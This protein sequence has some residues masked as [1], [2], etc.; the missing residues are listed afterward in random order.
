M[1]EFAYREVGEIEEKGQIVKRDLML[2]V[3]EKVYKLSVGTRDFIETLREDNKQFAE[4]LRIDENI[5]SID[6]VDNLKHVIDRISQM[7]WEIVA[8]YLIEQEE[9]ES[10]D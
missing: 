9:T 3:G 7:P 8:P 10:T 1:K 4:E 6:S 5:L 2:L